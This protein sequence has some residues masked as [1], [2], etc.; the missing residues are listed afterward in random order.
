[1]FAIEYHLLGGRQNVLQDSTRYKQLNAPRFTPHPGDYQTFDSK[2]HEKMA[3]ALAR[4]AN[5][6]N[7]WQFICAGLVLRWFLRM[8]SR[9][10][11]AAWL[12]LESDAKYEGE[13]SSARKR[14]SNL[15][16]DRRHG[17][18]L[19]DRDA[20]RALLTVIGWGRGFGEYS[21]TSDRVFVE[22]IV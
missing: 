11:Q 15:R 10:P 16:L 8:G 1:S 9:R 12:G 22:P 6:E 21:P 5:A 18:P 20:V 17:S 3:D 4:A 2:Y 19:L 13:V 7:S 14:L